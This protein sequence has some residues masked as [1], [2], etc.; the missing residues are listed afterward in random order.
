MLILAEDEILFFLGSM[1]LQSGTII[2]CLS[3]GKYNLFRHG[4]VC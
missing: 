2:K 4:F 3:V 1:I